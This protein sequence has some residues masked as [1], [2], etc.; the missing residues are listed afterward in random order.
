MCFKQESI[1]GIPKICWCGTRIKDV[2]NGYPFVSRSAAT[3]TRRDKLFRNRFQLHQMST[4][5]TSSGNIVVSFEW[6]ELSVRKKLL[7]SV[8]QACRSYPFQNNPT[9]FSNCSWQSVEK[10]QGVIIIRTKK[11]S[12]A[13]GVSASRSKKKKVQRTAKLLS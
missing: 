7:S 2:A 1:L 8:R 9:N 10:T 6:L 12:S 3:Q 13:V 5:C 11:K 4:S